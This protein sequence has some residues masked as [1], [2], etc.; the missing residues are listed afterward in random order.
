M[1]YQETY[2]ESINDP[3]GFWL[4]E[5]R[6]LA[7]MTEPQAALAEDEQGRQRWFRGGRLNVAQ[8]ALDVHVDA[9]RGDQPAL[10][11]DSPVSGGKE[12]YTYRQ[13]RDEVARAAGMLSDLGVGRGDRVVIYMPMIP[14]AVISMLACA[15]LGAIHSVVFGGFAANELA[16]RIDDASPRVVLTASCGIEVDR[17]IPYQPLVNEALRRAEHKPE[18]VIYVSRP[19]AGVEWDEERDLDWH[20]GLAGAA[21]ADPVPVDATD[22]LYILYTSG[23]TGKPKGVVRD[24]GG[25]AVALNWSLGAV[26]DLHPGDV[27]WTASDVGWVVGHSYIVYGPLIRGCTTVVYEGKPVRTPDAGAFWRVISEYRAKAF[28][29]APTAFRA[30]KKEDPEAR[31]LQRYDISCLENVF[32]AGER[33][34]PP[35]YEWLSQTLQ[36]PVIDHWWQTETGWPIVA[37]PMGIQPMPVKSGS[38]TVPMAGYDIRVLDDSGRELPAGEQGNLAIRLPLPPGCLPTLWNDEARFQKS[39]LERFPGF[40][41]TSDGGFIDEDGYVYV[42]GR[43]DDVINVAGHRLSTGEMEEVIGDHPAVAECAVVGIHDDTKGELPV[44]FV[45]LKDGSDIDQERIESDLTGMIRNEIGAIASLR[46]VAVVQKLPKTR[47]GK[48]L[49]KSIRTLAKEAREQVPTPSTID[50]VSSLDEIADAIQAYN[51]GRHT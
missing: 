46:R 44:A 49:R 19:Q 18:R 15:R 4:R 6:R 45:V 43:V 25:Y 50:D 40:Y 8:L 28:F 34:D 29:T 13:L 3:E 24:S 35:T 9:G 17:V 48:I 11:Y 1:S 32:V 27:F 33:L 41:D 22:P 21:P 16:V 38:A 12:Q 31:H 14:E 47:S 36:R 2:Q 5:A 37:N 10:L 39:Y 26:Y 42:M 51:L 23:T 7:W 20:T 30:I